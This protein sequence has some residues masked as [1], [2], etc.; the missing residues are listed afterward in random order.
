MKVPCFMCERRSARPL[1][2]KEVG[3]I[4]VN[5]E[6]VIL[7]CSV[8]CAANYALTRSAPQILESH[9]FCPW[10][11]KWQPDLIDDCHVCQGHAEKEK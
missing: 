6:R 11:G 7:F 1:T 9:H 4:Y 8:R 10:A 5:L 2:A 3:G